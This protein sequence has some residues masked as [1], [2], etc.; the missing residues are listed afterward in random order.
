MEARKLSEWLMD[1]DP[2]IRNSNVIQIIDAKTRLAVELFWLRLVFEKV[3]RCDS[4]K[5]IFLLNFFL[6]E[7]FSEH[8]Q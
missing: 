5:F 8:L 1:G 3:R 2:F 6:L 4:R 7:V